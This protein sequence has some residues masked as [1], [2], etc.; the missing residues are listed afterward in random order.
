[1]IAVNQKIALE[2]DDPT[3]DTSRTGDPKAVEYL[4]KRE[5]E[6]A[7]KRAVPPLLTDLETTPLSIKIESDK[8]NKLT[9]DIAEHVG[10]VPSP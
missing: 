3:I 10:A 5:E 8:S 9:V 6:L 1:V 7:S 4:K 2:T